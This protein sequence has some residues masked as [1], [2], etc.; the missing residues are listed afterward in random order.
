MREHSLKIWPGPFEAV[1]AGHKRHEVRVD[2]RGFEVGDVLHLRE[3]DPSPIMESFSFS[4]PKGCTGRSV[5]VLVTY[6]TAAGT[7]GMPSNLCVMS[8]EP[9]IGASP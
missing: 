9:I 2:D 6:V 8:I 7:W 1:V 3:W 4:N 5:R